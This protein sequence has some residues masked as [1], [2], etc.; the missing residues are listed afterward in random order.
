MKL[1][2]K[3]GRLLGICVRTGKEEE[4]IAFTRLSAKV[5]DTYEVHNYDICN[6]SNNGFKIIAE[7]LNKN[8][9]GAVLFSQHPT[10]QYE[11]NIIHQQLDFLISEN[12]FDYFATLLCSLGYNKTFNALHM[13]L[14]QHEHKKFPTISTVTISKN[15]AQALNHFTT[16]NEILGHKFKT[17]SLNANLLAELQ[18]R[19]PNPDP[20]VPDLLSTL[21][22][23][24]IDVTAPWFQELCFRYGTTEIY[25]LFYCTQTEKHHQLKAM[26]RKQKSKSNSTYLVRCLN[27]SLNIFSSFYNAKKN[28]SLASELEES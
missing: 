21:K 15:S 25:L 11:F 16:T 5:L 19:M 22:K 27:S 14:F 6:K 10:N 1:L 12:K 8:A 20:N 9:T 28:R 24:Q 18:K 26:Q 17:T 4:D 2:Y 13:Q 7:M 23:Q 3:I